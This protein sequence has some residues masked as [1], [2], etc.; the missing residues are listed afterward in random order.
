MTKLSTLIKEIV[1]GIVLDEEDREFIFEALKLED[2]FGSSNSID[3]VDK[4]EI[5]IEGLIK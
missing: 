5:M 3:L 4:Y 1:E 2:K